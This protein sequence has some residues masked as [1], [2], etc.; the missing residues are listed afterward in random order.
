MLFILMTMLG[1]IHSPTAKTSPTVTESSLP[2]STKVDANN[3]W[4]IFTDGNY[5]SGLLLR[6]N[7]LWAATAG[8]VVRWDIQAGTYRKYTTFDGLPGNYVQAIAEDRQGNLV[9]GT[10]YGVGIFD[11]TRWETLSND[12]G[13]PKFVS[14]ISMDKQNNLLVDTETGIVR[15]DGK[16]WQPLAG[17]H[18][19]V[20]PNQGGPMEIGTGIPPKIIVDQSGNIWD[21]ETYFLSRY[22][23]QKWHDFYGGGLWDKSAISSNTAGNMFGSLNAA[24][25]APDGSLWL[26]TSFGLLHF[27]GKVFNL[28]V[29]DNLYK[30]D[31]DNTPAG[32]TAL[33]LDPKGILLCA[34]GNT[35]L[36]YDGSS[37]QTLG[38]NNLSQR[39]IT[40]LTVDNQNNLWGGS[41]EGLYHFDGQHWKKYTTGDIIPDEGTNWSFPSDVDDGMVV[42]QN[43][44]LW[45]TNYEGVYRYDGQVWK[46]FTKA[47]GLADNIVSCVFPDKQ[48]NVW[49]GTKGSGVS[50]FDGTNWRTFTTSDILSS[51]YVIAIAQDKQ[52][53]FWFGNR[54]N[55]IDWFDGQ[56]WKTYSTH[57]ILNNSTQSVTSI[58]LDS[59]G[60]LWFATSGA[61]VMRYDGTNWTTFD[62]YNGLSSDNVL[63]IT[64]DG[65]G[66]MW[67]D[68]EQAVS[69]F[70]GS[71]WRTFDNVAPNWV[72]P[73]VADNSGNV[74]F[75]TQE[76]AQRYDGT[77][78][79][80]FT[81]PDGL[82]SNVVV[83]I[84]LAKD[85]S[86]W[87][88]TEMGVSHY[89]GKTWK[90]YTVEDGLATNYNT[91]I[92]V[93]KDGSLWFENSNE[94]S[95]LQ[96]K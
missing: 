36:R 57:D 65:N 72:R 4:T 74:W 35:I 1:C 86:L 50:R 33:A 37:S 29:P 41:G 11:G 93:G 16:T 24:I 85:E 9:C 17:P 96:I 88:G 44:Y 2:S 18:E 52:G 14:A 49:F 80:T 76:G 34:N 59:Q 77:N 55:K 12:K 28:L 67:F 71:N 84:A 45:L 61:G 21:V 39:P 42:D 91:D 70:D 43:G 10:F 68:C 48:G 87:F 3:S 94:I 79:R 83:A 19:G 15:Y 62:R 32:I 47:D 89:D 75:G 64:E 53:N 38:T 63:S 95:H 82:P 40:S 6:G 73:M 90:N 26:G 81:T 92:A 25:L 46:K 22:D 5:I 56:S 27:D 78:W 30:P 20:P 60:N 51:N 8:G 69:R 31:V 7:D 58:Y 13:F 23:G 66:N 54:G